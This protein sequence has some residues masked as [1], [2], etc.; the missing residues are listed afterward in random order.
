MN[1]QEGMQVEIGVTEKRFLAQLAKL[2]A[3]TLKA[4]NKLEKIW[5]SSNSRVS[6]SFQQVDRSAS[7]FAR[8]GMRNVSLQLSQV[9]QQASATGDPLRE[10]AIQLPDLT[11]GFGVLGI[12]IGAVAGALL[13]LAVDFFKSGE[14]ARDLDE[15]IGDLSASVERYEKALKRALTPSGDLKEEYGELAEQARALFEAQSKLEKLDA[16]ASLRDAQVGIADQF[17]SLA[18][19]TEDFARAFSGAVERLAELN[20]PPVNAQGIATLSDEELVSAQI[21]AEAL[22]SIVDAV[23]PA[24][25]RVKTELGLTDQEAGNFLA[26]LVRL[27]DAAP[28]AEM[29]AALAG[30]RTCSPPWMAA[31][32]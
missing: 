25:E 3:Q 2:E 20:N 16:L 29:Q 17:G 24:I 27:R 26:S 11:L 12:A 22:R 8:G 30:V 19:V 14:N 4:A 21:E 32:P 31:R 15:T 23:R 5:K 7:T 28:G 18:G 6:R 9:A 13:P 10:E 1:E